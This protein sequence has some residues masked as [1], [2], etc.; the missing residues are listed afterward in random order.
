MTSLEALAS[1]EYR[2]GHREEAF[3]L[4]RDAKEPPPEEQAWWFGRRIPFYLGAGHAHEAVDLCWQ[5]VRDGKSEGLTEAASNLADLGQRPAARDLF[6]AAARLTRDP[7]VRFQLQQALIQ[8]VYVEKDQPVENFVREM[9]RLQQFAKA[10]PGQRGKY[11][12]D[13]YSFAISRGATE[14]L[15]NVLKSEW[16]AGHGEIAAGDGLANLFIETKQVGRVAEF[17]FHH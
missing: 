12:Y 11:E 3:A 14:W 17:G 2:R 4:A 8:F 6:A 1:V 13:R 10:V 16:D 9:R 7:D 15:E 5:W